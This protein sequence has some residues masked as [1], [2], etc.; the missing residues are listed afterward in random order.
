[1]TPGGKAAGVHGE[2][3]RA[4]RSLASVAVAVALVTGACIAVVVVAPAVSGPPMIGVRDGADALAVTPDGRTLFVANGGDDTGAMQIVGHTVTPVATATGKPGRP[5]P[6]GR[7]PDALAVTPDGRTLF[8]A[9]ETGNTVTPV[10]LPA[11]MA[12]RPIRAGPNPQALAVTPDGRTLYVG[13]SGYVGVPGGVTPIDIAT[14]Q[15]RRLI[16]AANSAAALAVTP[17]GHTLY[18][19]SRAGMITPVD[20]AT[21][22]PGRPISVP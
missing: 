10:S 6:V 20:V 19:A 5:I 12:G 18:V 11:G 16:P 22:K 13:D 14:G 4:A 1:V 3:R 2:G 8:A 9:S 17:D 15:P 7:F 21:G